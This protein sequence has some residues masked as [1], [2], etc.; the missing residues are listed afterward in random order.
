MTTPAAVRL[1]TRA[2]H[3]MYAACATF[4]FAG[5]TPEAHADLTDARDLY[6]TTLDLLETPCRAGQ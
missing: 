2:K 5:H 1:H 3:A 6:Y 4:Y